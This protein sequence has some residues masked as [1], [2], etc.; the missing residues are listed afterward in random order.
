[1]KRFVY[2]GGLMWV[3]G[4]L[5]TLLV[6]ALLF[7]LYHATGLADLVTSVIAP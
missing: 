7:Y 1:M 5:L 3:G 6:A 2:L 4:G